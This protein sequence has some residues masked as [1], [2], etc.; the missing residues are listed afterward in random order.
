MIKRKVLVLLLLGGLGSLLFVQRSLAQEN[1]NSHRSEITTSFYGTYEYPD[2]DNPKPPKTE[3]ESEKNKV[4]E[5]QKIE[6]VVGGKIPQTGDRS[7][8]LNWF[9]GGMLMS[10]ALYLIKIIK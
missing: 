9:I 5:R 1:T 8:F 2:E 6:N 4:L 3:K 10:A 7:P